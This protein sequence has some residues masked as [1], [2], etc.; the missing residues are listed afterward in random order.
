ME[1]QI[2]QII[3]ANETTTSVTNDIPSNI[4]PEYWGSA[5]EWILAIAYLIRSIALLIRVLTPLKQKPAS[6]KK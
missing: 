5:P 4:P 2:D 1:G 3:S 6:E